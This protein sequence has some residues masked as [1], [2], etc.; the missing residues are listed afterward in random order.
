MTDGGFADLAATAGDPL[1][2]RTLAGMIGEA[3]DRLA[4]LP[5]PLAVAVEDP[6]LH[7][8]LRAIADLLANARSL[9]ETSLAGA[10]G[11]TAGFNASDGD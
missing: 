8:E 7:A 6:E 1:I 10:V 11:L 3:S 5:K 2:G 9:A 4:A